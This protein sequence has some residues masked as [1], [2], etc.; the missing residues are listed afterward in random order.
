MR[1]NEYYKIQIL[2]Q[3]KHMFTKYKK[4]MVNIYTQRDKMGQYQ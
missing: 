3:T 2:N 1:Y 4:H